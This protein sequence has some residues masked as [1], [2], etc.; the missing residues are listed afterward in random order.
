MLFIKI[1]IKFLKFKFFKKKKYYQVYENSISS[2]Y[3][4]FEYE[5]TYNRKKEQNGFIQFR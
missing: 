5:I 3:I 1:F 4:E 2:S